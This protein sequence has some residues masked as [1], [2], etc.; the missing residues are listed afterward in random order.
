MRT[1]RP[2]TY[3]PEDKQKVADLRSQGLSVVDVAATI[4]ITTKMVIYL[5]PKSFLEKERQVIEVRKEKVFALAREGKSQTEIGRLTGERV[6]TI[7]RWLKKVDIAP[8]KEMRILS[9][10]E[11]HSICVD[12]EGGLSYTQLAQKYDIGTTCV[13]EALSRQKCRLPD[14]EVAQRLSKGGKKS[15]AVRT[16]R[17]TAKFEVNTPDSIQRRAATRSTHQAEALGFAS[18]EKRCIAHANK[19]GGSAKDIRGWDN[20]GG[21]LCEKG[22]EWFAT[23]HNVLVNDTWCPYCVH[24]HSKAE[25]AILAAVKEK[26]PD[27]DHGDGLLPSSGL[28]LDIYVPSLRKAIEYDGTWFHTSEEAKERDARKDAE[29]IQV[30][31][32]LLRIPEAEYESDPPA[33]IHKALDFLSASK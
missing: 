21:W 5:T 29:C 28:K 10:G 4:G 8:F 32:K 26:Y 18:L 9:D 15:F 24:H 1:G 33:T 27:A 19:K 25:L 3:T 12:F 17:G 6:P 11:A 7:L 30:G 14:G 16:E 2:P 20:D 31:I 13:K 23:P 22:H